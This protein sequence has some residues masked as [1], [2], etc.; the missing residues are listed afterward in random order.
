MVIF[1]IVV[2]VNE[3]DA[4]FDAEEIPLVKL[5]WWQIDDVAVALWDTA[6]NR[7]ERIIDDFAH[8]RLRVVERQCGLL[9]GDSIPGR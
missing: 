2:A 9:I 7:R 4:S 8:D 6:N 3:A 1:V 5:N